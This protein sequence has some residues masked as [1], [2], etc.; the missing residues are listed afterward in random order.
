MKRLISVWT[1]CM[2]VFLGL[3]GC[4]GWGS[5]TQESEPPWRDA[6]FAPPSVQTSADAVFAIDAPMRDYLAR[7]IRPQL[8]SKGARQALIDALYNQGQLRL[9]YD[10]SSTRNAS[11]AFASRAGNCLSLVI[12]TAAFAQE[13]GLDVRFQQVLGEAE[14]ER[15][16]DLFFHI[17]HVNLAMGG[18]VQSSRARVVERGWLTIDFLPGRDLL[19]QR[20]VEIDSRRV[21]AMYLNNKAAEALVQGRLADAYWWTRAALAQDLGYTV[22]RNTLAVVYRRRGALVEAET[23]L[24]QGLRLEPDNPNLLGNLVSLLTHQGRESQAR[25]LQ[26]RLAALQPDAPMAR[27]M[28]GLQAMR[29]GDYRRARRLFEAELR[30]TPH[31]HE[32]HFWLAQAHFRL[33]DADAGRRHLE[34]ARDAAGSRDQRALYAAKLDKLKALRVQ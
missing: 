4:A 14:V 21:L 20:S 25:P 22:A 13:L 15:A 1:L 17:G 31:H 34:A 33:G 24:Q 19:G 6:L 9:E 28:L 8:H 2:G 32:F 23:V 7:H 27:F 18:A 10:S 5:V 30:R 29:E 16:G 12:M 3:A 11:E 26:A